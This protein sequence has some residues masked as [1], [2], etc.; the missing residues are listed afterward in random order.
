MCSKADAAGSRSPST[1]F[2]AP[3]EG[4]Q[5]TSGCTH[6]LQPKLPCGAVL[7]TLVA[8]KR[9]PARAPVPRPIHIQHARDHPLIPKLL[10]ST[11]KSL[12]HLGTIID[13]TE[14][15]HEP[16]NTKTSRTTNLSPKPRQ[17]NNHHDETNT[18]CIRPINKSQDT[19]ESSTT[20]PGLSPIPLPLL[21]NFSVPR[22]LCSA[23]FC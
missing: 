22:P 2:Q 23:I 20:Q 4:M 10:E 7:R 5:G 8:C 12:K 21:L 1:K 17:Y 13:N 9:P 11:A 6:K 14:T 16:I 19:A 18:E 3:S 15:D